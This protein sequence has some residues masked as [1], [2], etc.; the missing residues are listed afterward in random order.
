MVNDDDDDV[1][2]VE[3]DDNHVGEDEKLDRKVRPPVET[4]RLVLMEHAFQ[5]ICSMPHGPCP[6]AP[7]LFRLF[8]RMALC[9][10]AAKDHKKYANEVAHGLEHRVTDIRARVVAFESSSA[11]QNARYALTR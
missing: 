11:Q 6:R 1:H 2:D 10:L 7:P 8:L 3:N 4:S 5:Q 9:L